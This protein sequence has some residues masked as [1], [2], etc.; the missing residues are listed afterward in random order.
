[1]YD[2]SEVSICLNSFLTRIMLGT[3]AAM[4]FSDLEEVIEQL[5]VVLY[6]IGVRKSF[7]SDMLEGV[8]LRACLKFCENSSFPKVWENMV[9]FPDSSDPRLI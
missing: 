1:M 6:E 9:S 2:L 3:K 8:D 7:V 5:A 4:C